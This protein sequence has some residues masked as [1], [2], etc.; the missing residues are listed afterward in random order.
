MF[1]LQNILL[2]ASGLVAGAV[3]GLKVIAP[4][5]S[6]KVDDEVLARLEKLE[7]ML[8]LVVGK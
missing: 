5:T 4:L 2:V 3:V 1:T 8:A 7:Q 6:N